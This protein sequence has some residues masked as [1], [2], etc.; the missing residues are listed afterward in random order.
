MLAALLQEWLLL[1]HRTQTGI[2]ELRSSCGELFPILGFAVA[3]NFCEAV[4]DGAAAKFAAD[5]GSV[6]PQC[7]VCVFILDL[8]VISV[9]L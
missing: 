5:V 4:A 3:K 8:F 1:E 2:S 9:I 6:C 7:R